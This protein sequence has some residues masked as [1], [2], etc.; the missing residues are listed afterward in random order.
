VLSDLPRFLGRFP[1][2][3][4]AG[5]TL[6]LVLTACGGA[7]PAPTRPAASTTATDGNATPAPPSSASAAREPNDPPPYAPS[8]A[9]PKQAK[10]STPEN[11]AA[12]HAERV[13]EASV[14]TK[15]PSALPLP[16]GTTVLHVGDSFAGALGLPLNKR[17][18]A[19][20]IHS[21]LEFETA[22]YIPGWSSGDKLKHYI[23]RYN[24][25]LVLI[26]LGANELE[27]ANPEQRIRN[28]RKI[29]KMI[30][31]RPCVWIATPLWAGA[32]NGLFEIIRQNIAP[33]LYMDTNALITGMPRVADGIHPTLPAREDW[34]DVVV[35]WLTE[36]R[37]PAA[38]KPWALAE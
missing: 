9:E 37:K 35:K 29:V 24:P 25:D 7:A 3:A 38:E 11:E 16:S 1:I 30:G 20:G 6:A 32:K 26:T 18:K 27:I 14:E 12:H 17:L 10:A 8:S 5:A 34:A 21:V 13:A 19:A 28:I 23:N 4:G 15:G 36:H 31:E 22:S 33:C 2:V